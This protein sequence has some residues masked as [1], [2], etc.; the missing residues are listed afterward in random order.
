VANE[1]NKQIAKKFIVREFGVAYQTSRIRGVTGVESP[2][3]IDTGIK[4]LRKNG[5]YYA[6]WT[7]EKAALCREYNQKLEEFL[8]YQ[9]ERFSKIFGE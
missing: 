9:K 3:T 6:E 7:S 1:S 5:M 2:N 4:K 8:T